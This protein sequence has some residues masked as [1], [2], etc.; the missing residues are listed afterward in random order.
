M[1]GGVV[2]VELEV[3]VEVGSVVVDGA[4]RDV[5]TVVDV[6]LVAGVVVLAD[7]AQAARARASAPAPSRRRWGR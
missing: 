6:V 5:A 2:V 1:D 4:A 7:A 3:D